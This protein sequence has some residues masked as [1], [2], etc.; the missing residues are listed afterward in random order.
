MYAIFKHLVDFFGCFNAFRYSNRTYFV[1]QVDE[2]FKN[3]L[4]VIIAVYVAYQGSV[5]FNN[6]RFYSIDSLKV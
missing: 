5:Q 6:I 4:L 3:L 2:A 1:G